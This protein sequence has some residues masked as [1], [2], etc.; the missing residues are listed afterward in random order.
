MAWKI[1]QIS[2]F[3]SVMFTGI[4]YEWTPSGLALSIVAGLATLLA[5]VV[6]SDSLRLIGWASN[7]V[8]PILPQKRADQRFTGRRRPF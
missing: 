6:I 7:K 3:L 5:T 1:F 4:Y 2:V 8:G